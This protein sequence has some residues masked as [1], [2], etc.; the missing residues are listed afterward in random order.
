MKTNMIIISLASFF[1]LSFATDDALALRCGT[2]L[3]TEGDS[4]S[5]V[6]TT[7]GKPTS[8]EKSCENS[9]QYTTTNNN[10]KIKKVKKCG[11][12]LET[13]FYNCGDN[14]FIYKLIFDDG[15]IINITTESRGSGK[16]DCQGK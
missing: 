5:Q 12:K 4:K 8:K 6:L 7:C 3:V 2:G 16:S 10:G 13:W 9:Q 14:D 11:Q 1:F 15:K